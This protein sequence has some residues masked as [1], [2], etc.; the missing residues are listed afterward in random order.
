MEKE[1]LAPGILVYRNAIDENALN[2]LLEKYGNNLRPG[3]SGWY[4]NGVF[5]EDVYKTVRDVHLSII[6]DDLIKKDLDS[7]ILNYTRTTLGNYTLTNIDF[8]SL[9]CEGLQFLKYENEGHFNYHIDA[10]AVVY[11]VDSNALYRRVLSAVIYFNDDYNGGEL[12]FPMFDLK[13]KPS[14]RDIIVFP[15]GIPYGHQV[16]PVDGIRYAM[17]TWY[18]WK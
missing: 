12:Y 3:T 13:Y 1:I 16:M 10:A 5:K 4:E 11:H 14:P 2:R 6:Q 17:V 18:N 7:C 8:D 9:E 15:S